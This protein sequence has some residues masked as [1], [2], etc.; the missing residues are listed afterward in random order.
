MYSAAKI[1]PLCINMHKS[2]AADCTY[3]S[4]TDPIANPRN[5][6]GPHMLAQNSKA[7]STSKVYS[8]LFY[9]QVSKQWLTSQIKHVQLVA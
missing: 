1:L 9:L 3:Y 2:T 8:L 7:S 6:N 5:P 4:R